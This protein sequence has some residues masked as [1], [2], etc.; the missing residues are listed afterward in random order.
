MRI[1]EESPKYRIKCPS[2]ENTYE[3]RAEEEY[4]ICPFPYTKAIYCPKCKE[5]ITTRNYKFDF[6]K[7]V[8]TS[9]RWRDEGWLKET[10]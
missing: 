8:K 5:T 9:T 7:R 6:R 2:C 3:F 10:H 4:N 1:V